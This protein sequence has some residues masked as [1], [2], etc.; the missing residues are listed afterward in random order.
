M[1]LVSKYASP[2]DPPNPSGTSEVIAEYKKQFEMVLFG[3]SDPEK[4]AGAFRT[5]AEEALKAASK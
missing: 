1:D 3:E 4:A 5:N 2:I